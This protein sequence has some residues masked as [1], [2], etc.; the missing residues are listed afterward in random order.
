MA[1]TLENAI[2]FFRDFGLFDVVLPFLLVFTIIFAILEKTRILGVEGSGDKTIPKKNLNSMVAF[3]VALLVVATNKIVNALN[4]ALPNVVLL[5]VVSISFL[6][7]IGVFRKTEE[8][9]FSNAHKGYYK[10]FVLFFLLAVIWIFMDALPRDDGLSWG[11]YFFNYVVNNASGSVVASFVFLAIVIGTVF[12]VV[13][14]P[15][16]PSEG[17]GHG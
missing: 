11:D 12:Y 2:Q 1:S 7:L 16:K 5:I 3:V 4:Q 14:S 10:I 9:D 13:Q 15:T 6:L 17:G 8:F